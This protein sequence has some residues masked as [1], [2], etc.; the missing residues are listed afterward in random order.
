MNAADFDQACHFISAD[1]ERELGLARLNGKGEL[2]IPI[3]AGG[4]NLLAALGL[5]CYTEFAGKLR[6]GHKN[7]DGSDASRKN[8]D[9][10]FRLLGPGYA[11][12]ANAHKVYDIFRCGLAHEYY[13]KK[14]CTVNILANGVTDGIGVDSGGNYFIVVETYFGALKRQLLLLRDHLFPLVQEEA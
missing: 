10:F 13:V 3:P 6:F 14:T 7:R 8:F 2:G 1:I 12:F 11:S 5:L 4:G 9:S